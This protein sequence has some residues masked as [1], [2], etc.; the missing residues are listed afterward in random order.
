ML[1]EE[2]FRLGHDPDIRG[3]K[4]WQNI[5]YSPAAR[6]YSFEAYR[7]DLVRDFGEYRSQASLMQ[8]V[9]DYGTAR[10]KGKGVEVI[11]TAFIVE[12]LHLLRAW[13]HA[14][15]GNLCNTLEE[16]G[17]ALEWKGKV[18]TLC[19]VAGNKKLSASLN[20][21]KAGARGQWS[22]L[23]L[24]AGELKLANPSR[25]KGEIIAQLSKFE[26]DGKRKVG[27]G[28]EFDYKVSTIEKNLRGIELRQ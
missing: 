8:K 15:E 24:R 23:I 13:E 10:S 20:K 18:V 19:E 6:P 9:H 16:L 27:G 14:T 1:F 5:T 12:L 28:G 26:K 11:R 25:T 4:P 7:Q 21:M 22:K 17:Y 3:L 2:V